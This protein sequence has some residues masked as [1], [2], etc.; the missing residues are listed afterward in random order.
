MYYIC[1][2]TLYEG[3]VR[4]INNIDNYICYYRYSCMYPILT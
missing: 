1:N 4:E 3:I 2:N